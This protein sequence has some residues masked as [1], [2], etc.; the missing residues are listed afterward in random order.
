MA[1]SHPDSRI[2][3]VRRFGRFYTQRIQALREAYL[4]TRF[5]LAE[6]RVIYELATREAVTATILGRD[7]GLDSG[8]L[9]RI[10][11]RFEADGLLAR[12]R[13]EGDG[14]TRMLRL[15]AQGRAAFA[16]LDA[17]QDALVADMLAELPDAA[18]AE[19]VAAMRRI[20]TLLGEEP[21]RG[22]LL[23]GLRPGDL[24]WIVARHGALYAQEY[25]W[26]QEFEILVARII[27]EAMETF[28]PACEGAWMAERDGVPVGS[29][30]LVRVDDE[31]AKLRIL[32][33]EPS[34]RG[35]GIG[36]RLV[37]ECTGFARR[38]G[39]R[40]ITLWTHSVLEGARRLYARA[41][42]RIVETQPFRGFG[43]ELT[44]EIWQLDL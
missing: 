10:V 33:V 43:Q 7:L 3:A 14:R 36:G 30:F 44:N 6:S 25:G 18:A 2:A 5:S 37:E 21:A 38:A 24:G 34:A 16:P 4:D 9:S 8:Y 11:R 29:V 15:T 41:G 40:R 22:W 20:E 32:L 19:A 1:M 28:D 42:Y 35:L 12:E 39:Y 23:R 17:R 13:S 27:A 26:N 31:T